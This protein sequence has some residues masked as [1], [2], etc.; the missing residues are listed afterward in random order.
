MAQC[1]RLLENGERCSNPALPGSALC[2]IHRGVVFRPLRTA[3]PDPSP[4]VQASASPLGSVPTFPGLR[5]D[6]RN[7]LVGPQ[8]VIWLERGPDDDFARLARVVAL[9]SQ[10]FPL[11]GQARLL[12]GDPGALVLLTPAANPPG[13]LSDW[14]DAAARAGGRLYVGQDN[15]F[16][17]YRD[18]EA[19]R[20]YDAS[21]PATP[22]AGELLL[23]GR[24]GPRTLVLADFAE[25]SLADF[26]V[27]I[28]PL[29]EP[30][31]APPARVYAL[32]PPALYRL[33]AGHFRTHRVRCAL[34]GLRLNDREVHL[35]EVSAADRG[36]VP[37]FVLDYL[38]RLPRV[39]VLTEAHAADAQQFL[40]QW[41]YHHPMRLAHVASAFGP[42]ELVLLMAEHYPSARVSPTPQFHDGDA[43]L[44]VHVP[45]PTTRGT[46]AADVAPPLRLQVRLAPSP[47]PTPPLAALLLTE[48][49]VGW[50]RRLLFRLPGDRLAAY[51]LYHGQEHSVLLG[52]DR[53][54]EGVP[55]GV[56]LRRLGDT[57]LFLPLR[58]R[59]IPELSP[60]LLAEALEVGEDHCTVLTDD[61][62][63]DLPMTAF[64]PLTR[65]LVDDPARPRLRVTLA[66][67]P[68]LPPLRWKAPPA[69]VVA[70]VLPTGPPV[71]R[72]PSVREVTAPG[73]LG[74]AKPRRVESFPDLDEHLR[75]RACGCEAAGDF[76][77]AAVLYGL[78]ND[79]A[80]CGRCYRLAADDNSGAGE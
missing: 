16:V 55:F 48:R 43:L 2:K 67:P 38:E 34:A 40:V 71:E 31:S 52:E 64:T 24:D 76:L 41:G 69:P 25:V 68:E 45:R 58:S 35:F 53:P 20:G 61:G 3:V 32:A 70:I 15:T 4:T 79:A 17:L 11:P 56:P 33:L 39:T 73:A 19:P 26:C 49:E 5:A 66:V 47:G 63:F 42:G 75:L 8:G 59:L 36:A 14:Y 23:V 10:A 12:R 27:Q 1:E 22:P 65:G 44:Q 29:P 74:G 80:N 30:A 50:L 78:V 77:A 28:A 51:C 57:R 13:G 37:G 7:V 6:E 54:I 62:R 60:R 9:L 72:P 46:P 21:A 18:E